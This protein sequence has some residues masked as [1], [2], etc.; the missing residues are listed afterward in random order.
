[1]VL[2][3]TAE[4]AKGL[5][6][7]AI[8][9]DNPV[10]FME[11]AGL[12]AMRGEVPEDPDF[13]VPFGKA[14]IRR[15]GSDVT[16]IGY[17]IMVRKCLTAAERLEAEGVSCEVV[18]LRT[19]TPLDMDTIMGSVSRTHRVVVTQEEWRNV[20]FAAEIAARLADEGFD[21]LDAPV[22]R[23]GGA[24]VPMPYAKELEQAAIPGVE[25]IVEAVRE[26]MQ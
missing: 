26:V 24:D 14:A 2:P 5:L 7:T 15:E 1:V 8:R 21:E 18:D 3:Y 6:K 16:L 20:G 22:K 25:A 11:H 10:I 13:A 17:S 23:V 4:D 19:L 12:Y 9:D